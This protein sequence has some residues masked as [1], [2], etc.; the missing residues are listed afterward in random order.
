MFESLRSFLL[1]DDGGLSIAL[2]SVPTRQRAAA[3]GRVRTMLEIHGLDPE[4]ARRDP[5]QW[6]DMLLR[7]VTCAGRKYCDS[8]FA[9][10][11]AE[12]PDDV[13]FCPNRKEMEALLLRKALE[14]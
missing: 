2:P 9:L 5:D 12:V 4:L 1:P 10:N 7:C 3:E 13:P 11:D 8:A 6:Q 14:E